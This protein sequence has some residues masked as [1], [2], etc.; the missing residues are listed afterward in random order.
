MPDLAHWCSGQQQ[1]QG[2]GSG[3][4]ETTTVLGF[5]DAGAVDVVVAPAYE[6]RACADLLWSWRLCLGLTAVSQP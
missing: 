5:W 4:H 2:L 1:S 6:V 3:A